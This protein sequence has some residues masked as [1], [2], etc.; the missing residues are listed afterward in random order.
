MTHV[1]FQDFRSCKIEEYSDSQCSSIVLLPCENLVTQTQSFTLELFAELK[2]LHGP[3]L[4]LTFQEIHL[5]S[6]YIF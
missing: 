2:S 4:A 3:L 5:K 6:K 1:N